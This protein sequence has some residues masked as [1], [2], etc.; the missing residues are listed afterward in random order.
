[1]LYIKPTGGKSD[2]TSLLGSKTKMKKRLAHSESEA[3]HNTSTNS[4]NH[5]FIGNIN[6]P[7]SRK[8]LTKCPC[9]KSDPDSWMLTC[10]SC[11]QQW[12]AN[13]ANIRGKMK[14]EFVN[15]L[16]SWECPWCFIPCVVKETPNICKTCKNSESIRSALDDDAVKQFIETVS[17]VKKQNDELHKSVSQI[18][19]F[20]LHIKHLLLTDK[21]DF[22]D[23]TTNI[24]SIDDN[25]NI[26][27][28]NIEKLTSDFNKLVSDD[29]SSKCSNSNTVIDSLT[30]DIN[31]LDE[32]VTSLSSKNSKF[33]DDM[34][35]IIEDT[36]TS[37]DINSNNIS[38]PSDV[39]LLPNTESPHLRTPTPACEPYTNFVENA[40]NPELKDKLLEFVNNSSNDF[41]I[42]GDCRD[43]LY[44]G[45]YGY[46]YTGVYHP[47]CREPLVLQDLLDSLRPN[48]SNPKS[49][50]NSCLVTRYKSGSDHI[51]PHRDNEVFI[52]PESDI[53]TV[54]IGATR[55]I[56]FSDNSS[57][58]SKDL[59]LTDCSAYIMSRHSQDF[60]THGIDTDDSVD[61]VRY[62]FT[63]RHISPHFSNSTVIIGD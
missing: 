46:W 4:G 9:R 38:T 7:L 37:R 30:V 61:A 6:S 29:A 26:I 14:K 62:S 16:E 32:H 34:K 47:P 45:E 22:K 39:T 41:K 54:S 25:I 28:D 19:Y 44:F 8:Q 11:N 42:I 53:I 12:H 27:H 33:L 17:Y 2:N 40:V 31:R 35:H 18:E 55:T 63:F 60:W 49:L 36:S 3:G 5:S 50:I 58:T 56:S 51:P 21:K 43:V 57:T 15:S 13:C 1:M 48:F 20:N 23:H 10:V 59:K 52:D 24:K